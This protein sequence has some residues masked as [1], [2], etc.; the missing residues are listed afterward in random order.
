MS[1]KRGMSSRE[2]L[3]ELGVGGFFFLAIGLLILFTV[4]LQRDTFF[5]RHTLKIVSFETTGGLQSGDKVRL[6]GMVAGKVLKL[7]LAP[8]ATKINVTMGLDKPL[9]FYKDYVAEIRATS[10]LGGQ[11]VYLELG[12]PG[13]GLLDPTADLQGQPQ[14]DVMK[15]VGNMSKKLDGAIGNLTGTSDSIKTAADNFNLAVTD[16]RAGKGTIGKLLTDDQLYNDA[17]AAVADLRTATARIADENSTLGKVMS[18]K[19]ALYDSLKGSFDTFGETMKS[20]N[21]MVD[22]VKGGQ[23]TLGKLVT[24]DS[25][26]NDAKATVADLRTSVQRLAD[27]DSTLSKVMSDKGALYDSVKGSFDSFGNTMKTANEVAEDI[28]AGKGTLGKLAKDESLYNDAKAAVKEVQGA[29]SDFR[30]Q[31]P[32]LTFGSFLFGAL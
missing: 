22:K 10:M 8:D 19:G 15:L 9:A 1:D 12:T 31:S 18:D 5:A 7:E 28:K 13:A 11:Y 14:V 27:P 4:V 20:T 2:H 3:I 21:D 32:V 26:Y 29:V 17:K 23:G 6:R 24:D 25:L 30:E 16:A